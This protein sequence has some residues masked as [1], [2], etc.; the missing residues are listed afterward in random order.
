MAE[1]RQTKKQE[2]ASRLIGGPARHIMLE[3]GGRS[4][5]TFKLCMAIADRALL[6]PGS[7]HLILRYRY[8]HVM[9]SVWYDTWPKM[10]GLCYPGLKYEE[11]KS[12]SYISLPGGS[13]V[14]FGGLDDNIAAE[15]IL[16]N[17]YATIFPNECSQ[18]PYSSIQLVRTRLA[19]RVEYRDQSGEIKTLR[20]K[21]FYD[22]N[23]PGKG[24]WTYKMFHKFVD[25]E[26][27]QPLDSSNY[28]CLQMNP[29]DNLENIA[30]EY[31]E[32]LS[33]AAERV[34]RR[35]L[36]GEY[37]D[38][39]PNALF[40]EEI[41]D[42]NREITGKVPEMVRIIVSVD[43][44]GAGDSENNDNDAIGITVGGLGTDGNAYLL[45]DLT[46][47]AGPGTW[48]AVANRAFD[49]HQANLVVGEKNYGGAMV[50]YTIQATAEKMG[51]RCPPFKF[52]Q[53]TRG[54]SVRAEPIAAL[55]ESG[56]VRHVGVFKELEE[57]LCGFSTSGYMGE[58]SP[59]RADSWVWCLTELF[60]GIVRQEKEKLTGNFKSAFTRSLELV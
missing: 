59:N 13:E 50:Q 57:E 32:E 38:E 10:M 8:N 47:K 48:G 5:K 12:S 2:E 9:M 51:M 33:G 19:Q 26:S 25:P 24:H 39:N 46:V 49:R 53:A 30:P 11:H 6:A 41:I 18:I 7:R 23:P 4:S 55:Y 45:E 21:M 29:M 52:V 14:W 37:T 1:F 34:K 60:P 58:K 56:K 40:H 31:I 15:K 28:A 36:R 54:K 42:R 20:L 43:P 3:G 44:S 35:F 17:E 16:G 27:G 22:Q